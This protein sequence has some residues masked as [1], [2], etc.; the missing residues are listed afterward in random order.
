MGIEIGLSLN[1]RSI[2]FEIRQLNRIVLSKSKT[3][4]AHESEEAA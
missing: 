1:P 3:Y 2:V 4:R